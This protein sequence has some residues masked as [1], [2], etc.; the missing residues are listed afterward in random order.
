MYPYWRQLFWLVFQAI[1]YCFIPSI[2]ARISWGAAING[3][4]FGEAPVYKLADDMMHEAKVFA[5]SDSSEN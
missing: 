5:V 4:H 2:N 1:Y 3:C